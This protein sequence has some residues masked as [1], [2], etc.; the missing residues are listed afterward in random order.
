M[1]TYPKINYIGNKSRLV[2]WIISNMPIKT[3]VVVDLFSGGASVSYELKKQG[4]SV[5]AN[6]CLYSNYILSKAIIENPKD[7]LDKEV[8]DTPIPEKE[9]NK[10][11]NEISKYLS[12]VLYYDYEVRELAKF[13]RIS[14]TL[15]DYKKSL[16]L[17]LIRRSMIRKLPYSRMNVPWDQIQKLRDEEYSYIKY[18]RKR[19][20]HNQSFKELMLSDLGNYNQC[21]FDNEKPNHSFN[22]DAFDFIRKLN[23]KVDAIYMDPPYPRTMNKYGDFYGLYDKIF[24]KEIDYINLEQNNDFLKNLVTLIEMCLDKT[25]YIIIS[26]NNKTSPSISEIQDAINSFGDTSI[27]EKRHQYKVTNKDNKNTTVEQLLILKVKK[28]L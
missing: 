18:G 17:A 6:D 4:F 12:N 25:N 16:L 11:Y 7:M 23:N 2:E 3:G 22:M 15:Q 9:I 8:F 14:E 5:M 10:K 28:G 19:A 26:L 24:N 1:A 20:Y 27:V 21:V 13:I